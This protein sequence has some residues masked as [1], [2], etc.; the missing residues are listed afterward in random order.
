MALALQLVGDAGITQG[1]T[2]GRVSQWNDQSGNARHAVIN[3]TSTNE[4]QT[5]VHTSP[6]GL[7]VVTFNGSDQRIGG[8]G[9]NLSGITTAGTVFVVAKSN[10][11][12][13]AGYLGGHIG[14][15]TAFAGNYFPGPSGD[16]QVYCDY[17][18]TA[19]KTVGDIADD[20]A[21]WHV[22][23]V[24]SAASDWRFYVDGVQ[25]FS[26]ATNT[27]GFGSSVF[28]GAS[29]SSDSFPG[30]IAEIRVYDTALD[31]TT[32]NGVESALNTKWLVTGAPS[33]VKSTMFFGA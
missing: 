4:P 9:I 5:G 17:G 8:A 6:S 21:Q 32:R 29:V 22:F 10:A 1:T 25:R 20:L 26:T 30:R 24:V 19:R 11:D 14:C 27:A 2:S 7:N 15:G 12:P 13:A 28:I 16:A 3:Q 23:S 33:V 31:D 18:S